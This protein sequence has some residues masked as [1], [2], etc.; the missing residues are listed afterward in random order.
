MERI[1]VSGTLDPMAAL[2]LRVQLHEATDRLRPAITVDLTHVR[3]VHLAGV[4]TLVSAA[5]R[6]QRA[7]GG[8]HVVLPA[9]PSA[10]RAMELT[11][12]FTD[13]RD[14]DSIAG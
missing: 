9:D 14:S 10:R 13:E 5:R 4:S 1:T 8:L 7:G 11:A 6:A 3:Q 12:W 2:D